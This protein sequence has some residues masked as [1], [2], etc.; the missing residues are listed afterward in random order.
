MKTSNELAQ[1]FR[2]IEATDMLGFFGSVLIPR[3]EY[4][5]AKGWLSDDVTLSEWLEV[6]AN[7][8]MSQEAIIEEMRDY[9]E[10]AWGKCEEERGISASRSIDKFSAWLLILNDD[11]WEELRT[12]NDY[13]PYGAP[14][15]AKVSQKFGFNAPTEIHFDDNTEWHNPYK[16][17]NE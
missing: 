6:Q 5:D 13:S 9:M 1:V 10:F 16:M 3:L 7:V 11:L 17:E 15:L 14:L 12:G 4:N 2:T 8:P